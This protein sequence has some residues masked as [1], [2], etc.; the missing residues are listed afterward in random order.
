MKT[1]IKALNFISICSKARWL[2][3]MYISRCI[4]N[5]SR[6]WF[7]FIYIYI[8]FMLREPST[9]DLQ[10]CLSILTKKATPK[11][12]IYLTVSYFIPSSFHIILSRLSS[13]QL[14]AKW[15][16]VYGWEKYPGYKG[17]QM[18]VKI[19]IMFFYKKI[20]YGNMIIFFNVADN[21]KCDSHIF[22]WKGF[23]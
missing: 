7:F 14:T 19:K 17:Y 22:F 5:I 16:I 23:L 18:Y 20:Y 8:F 15:K 1:E 12:N 13:A 4:I 6:G 21:K 2:F 11:N 3:F 9:R 10:P